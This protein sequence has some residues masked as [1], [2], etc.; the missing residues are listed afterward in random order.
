MKAVVKSVVKNL[1]GPYQTYKVRYLFNKDKNQLYDSLTFLVMERVLGENTVCVDVGC[2]EGVVLDVMLERAPE[3]TFYAFE[4]LPHLYDHLVRRYGDNHRVKLHNLA[5]SN[6]AGTTSFNHVITNP[7]YSGFIKRRY[8]RPVEEDTQIT[9]HT[10]L[11]DNIVDPSDVLGFIKIDVEGA[12]L[13][14]LE[15]ARGLIKKHKPVIVFEHG[16]GAADI[17]GTTPED[18]FNLLCVE[19]GLQI[20]LMERWLKNKRPLSLEE[21]NQQFSR[22][23]NYYFIAYPATTN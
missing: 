2:H 6:E 19:C 21:F 20:S 5:L 17:Y 8:D 12:E 7:G 11:L 18:I 9:V 22:G 13:Q 1:L 4:P 16:L 14:V 3:G 23:L 15:G 10:E